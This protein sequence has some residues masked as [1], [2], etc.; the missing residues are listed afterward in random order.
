MKEVTALMLGAA[1]YFV[2]QAALYAGWLSS[3]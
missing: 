2:Y 3:S 1:A